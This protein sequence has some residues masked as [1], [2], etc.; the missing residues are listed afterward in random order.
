MTEPR[1][2]SK[3]YANWVQRWFGLESEKQSTLEEIEGLEL[4]KRISAMQVR[5]R[6]EEA[7]ARR[8]LW[9][10]SL[11]GFGLLLWVVILGRQ[12]RIWDTYILAFAIY[13]IFFIALGLQARG[14]A[15]GLLD[16]IASLE[17]EL[18]LHTYASTPLEQ[19]AEKLLSINHFQLRKYYQQNLSQ[20][21]A[22]FLIGV[23]CLLLGVAVTI[24]TIRAVQGVSGDQS[25]IVIGAVGTIGGVLV[26]YVAAV[27][28]KMHAAA[29]KSV[30]DF[31]RALVGT[32]EL[33]VAHLLVSRISDPGKRADCLAGMAMALV[34]D[35]RPANQPRSESTDTG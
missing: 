18:E 16:D 10:G 32:Q 15:K 4:P 30:N 33:F 28:L 14:T 19:R 2:Q 11:V 34:A 5:R 26:N 22:I 20:S 25:Q 35:G 31:H 7:R 27:Y 8:L 29:V 17:A 23:G 1:P 6:R 9:S 24:V 3:R 12:G 13:P 21:T